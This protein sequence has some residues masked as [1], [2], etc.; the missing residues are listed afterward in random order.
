M[1]DERAESVDPAVAGSGADASDRLTVPVPLPSTALET[2][3]SVALRAAACV[4]A[5]YSNIALLDETRA[6][7]RLFHGSFLDPAIADRY[8][9][10]ALDA[11]APIA[12]AVQSGE[13][14]FLPDLASYREHFPEM[15]PDTLAAGVGGTA[16]LPVFKADGTPL[17]AIGFA[18][19]D[20][21][22]FDVKLKGALEAVAL[23]CTEAVEQAQRY[24]EE[25]RVIV[26]LQRR[27]LDDLPRAQNIEVAAR[28]LP[29]GGPTSV[30][31]DWY[32]GLR[33]D[34]DQIAFVVGDVTGHGITAAA[35]MALV[36]GMITAL[37]H[38][39]VAVADVFNEVSQVMRQRK[40]PLL[41]TAA[42]VVLN[43]ATETLTFATAGH[44]PPIVLDPDG[45]MRF[46]DTANGPLIG[47]AEDFPVAEART[48]SDTAPFV[49]GS[50]L[51][52]Y[53]DG[54]VER[55]DRAFDAGIEQVATHL[56]GLPALLR[57]DA[58][59]DSLLDALIGDKAPADDIAIVIVE[60]LSAAP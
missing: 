18:W 7:L 10:L 8:T 28:Y 19:T 50:T 21:P 31:G 39:G 37:L 27:L 55:R 45:Q 25:H 2:A 4:A 24:D 15:V 16:S 48:L 12:V 20:P 43:T 52:I 58:L 30:G 53:T 13:P 59:I 34:A 33:V 9:D 51:V 44:P 35:D 54:L 14:V 3:Q 32:E 60:H 11:R 1:S 42:L 41:A 36:R 5:E 26:E 38:S 47:L 22:P 6:S 49:R 40:A 46:L 56:A 57:P 29:A 23:L 17:G